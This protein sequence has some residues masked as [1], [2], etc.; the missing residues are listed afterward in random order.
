MAV[1]LE[2][3]TQSR[4]RPHPAVARLRG[5]AASRGAVASEMFFFKGGKRNVVAGAGRELREKFLGLICVSMI[6]WREEGG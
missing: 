6:L 1:S 4:G 5:E 2:W 3:S